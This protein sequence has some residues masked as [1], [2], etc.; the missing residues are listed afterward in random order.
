VS[1]QIRDALDVH[2]IR[3]AVAPAVSKSLPPRLRALLA[4]AD[5]AASSADNIGGPHVDR[6]MEAGLQPGEITTLA[7]IVAAAIYETSFR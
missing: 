2:L 3:A 1:W 7:K 5:A 4:F 6:L